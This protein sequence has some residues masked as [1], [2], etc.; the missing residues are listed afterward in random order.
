M[1][2]WLTLQIRTIF[3]HM[4]KFAERDKFSYNT[5]M[6]R[7]PE[8]QA[9]VDKATI[10]RRKHRQAQTPAQRSARNRRAYLTRAQKPE[11]V[12]DRKARMKVYRAANADKYRAYRAAYRAA[13]LKATPAWAD[14]EKVKKIYALAEQHRSLTG[15]IVHVDHMVPLVHKLVCGLHNEFNLQIVIEGYNLKKNNHTWP[16]MP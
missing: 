3:P 7:T 6:E 5:A 15:E 8:Q 2:T 13:K 11:Y 1:A 14:N 10:R 16:D 4:D 12:A 9:A